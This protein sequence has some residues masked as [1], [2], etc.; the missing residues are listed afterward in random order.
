MRWK[1]SHDS[2]SIKQS[3]MTKCH[4][5]S[6]HSVCCHL[7]DRPLASKG[8]SRVFSLLRNCDLTLCV[9]NDLP[10]CFD[11]MLRTGCPRSPLQCW[12]TFPFLAF[13]SHFCAACKLLQWHSN[14]VRNDSVTDDL[15][16]EQGDK[17]PLKV[18]FRICGGVWWFCG[19]QHFS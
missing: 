4:L 6:A 18:P 11:W 15:A 12:R 7:K 8:W 14:I 16:M 13:F 9:I 5:P 17:R 19:R 2:K 3:A 1:T 10:Y